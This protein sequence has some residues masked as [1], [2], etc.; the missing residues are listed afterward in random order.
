MSNIRT[1]EM[2]KITYS[3]AFLLLFFRNTMANFHGVGDTLR[4]IIN[5]FEHF[6]NEDS[7]ISKSDL[8]NYLMDKGFPED[9]DVDE[10]IEKVYSRT[11][12]FQTTPILVFLVITNSGVTNLNEMSCAPV[13]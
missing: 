6:G 12:P 3:S 13:S 1:Q 4:A 5:Y 2:R 8:R 7:R 9:Q 11:N 10:H